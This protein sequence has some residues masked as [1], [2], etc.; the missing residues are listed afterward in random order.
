VI[1]C[2]YKHS[3]QAKLLVNPPLSAFEAPREIFFLERH[4]FRIAIQ[5]TS[6]PALYLLALVIAT[7]TTTVVIALLD[8]KSRR[9]CP[10]AAI[11]Y[12]EIPFS[13]C[14]L[15]FTATTLGTGQWFVHREGVRKG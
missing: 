15:N 13:L 4:F 12:F 11:Y 9:T 8:M 1:V 7:S 6:L 5:V 2:I 14:I 10:Q 3:L